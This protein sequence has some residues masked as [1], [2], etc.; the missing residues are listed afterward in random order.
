MSWELQDLDE[1]YT[2]HADS[3]D[4][5]LKTEADSYRNLANRARAMINSLDKAVQPRWLYRGNID[6]QRNPYIGGANHEG[7]IINLTTGGKVTVPWTRL[8]PAPLRDIINGSMDEE[9]AATHLATLNDLL[10]LQPE[11]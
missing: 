6:A 11:E 4:P 1:L 3:F 5:K 8:D 10:A 7:L 9:A 2:E